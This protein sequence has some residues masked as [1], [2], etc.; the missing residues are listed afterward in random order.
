[1]GMAYH[2]QLQGKIDFQGMRPS[3]YA[4]VQMS[5]TWQYNFKITF[6]FGTKQKLCPKKTWTDW[7][8][9]KSLIS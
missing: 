5:F 8:N 4:Q 6:D 9:L 1:M 3:F 2:S 7:A